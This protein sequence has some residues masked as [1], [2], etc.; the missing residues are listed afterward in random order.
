MRVRVCWTHREVFEVAGGVAARVVE[1]GGFGTLSV[2]ERYVDPGRSSIGFGNGEECG[3]S[4][5][6]KVSRASENVFE[7]PGNLED[8][9]IIVCRRG[10]GEEC[11]KRRNRKDMR[12]RQNYF[13]VPGIS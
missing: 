7:F 6:R 2:V 4:A 5:K 3:R 11:A 9:V 12:A 13:E 10:N 8:R 1:A